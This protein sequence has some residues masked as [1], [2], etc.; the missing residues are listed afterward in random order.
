MR[1][2]SHGARCRDRD[3]AQN[4][5]GSK[6]GI[7]RFEAA[8]SGDSAKALRS[9]AEQPGCRV[10][11]VGPVDDDGFASTDEDLGSPV[12]VGLSAGAVAVGGE[13]GRAR[14]DGQDLVDV[15]VGERCAAGG[16]RCEVLR[17]ACGGRVRGDGEGVEGSFTDD[18]TGVIVEWGLGGPVEGDGLGVDVGVGL[19]EVLG[20]GVVGDI[21]A[22]QP[23]SAFV[24]VFD[25]QDG[26]VPEEVDDG[27]V[28]VAGGEAA[29]DEFVVAEP[30]AVK[31]TDQPVDA[32][33]LAVGVWPTT[34]ADSSASSALT[35]IP[36]CRR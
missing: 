7:A 18:D 31:P 30:V 23:D 36:R 25:G 2:Q 15:V 10:F 14:M 16:D 1:S 4:I 20:L 29:V 19:V 28:G 35:S 27:P 24:V 9:V 22:E 21:S 3:Y 6:V 26:S 12:D 32:S 33:V 34:G 8:F 17:G 13:D 5:S 11:T